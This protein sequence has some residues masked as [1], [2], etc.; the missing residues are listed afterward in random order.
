MIDSNK[1][2]SGWT[3]QNPL[4]ESTITNFLLCRWADDADNGSKRWVH[5][6]NRAYVKPKFRRERSWSTYVAPL[7]TRGVDV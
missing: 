7:Q 3:P 4:S 1:F 6:D 5:F 2:F